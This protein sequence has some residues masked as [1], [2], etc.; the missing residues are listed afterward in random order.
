MTNIKI[1]A[2]KLRLAVADVLPV[3]KRTPEILPVSRAIVAIDDGLL[4]FTCS[5]RFILQ[6]T[7]VPQSDKGAE[8]G[9]R[10]EFAL[11]VNGVTALKPVAG[12]T[13]VE[14]SVGEASMTVKQYKNGHLLPTQECPIFGMADVPNYAPFV[15]IVS[16]INA[17]L[18]AN[19][20]SGAIAR[21]DVSRIKHIKNVTLLSAGAGEESGGK[22]PVKGFYVAGW[23]GFPMPNTEGVR[24]EGLIMPISIPG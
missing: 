13:D 4:T 16:D 24:T 2:A 22:S 23:H 17:Y 8:T 1:A 19:P 14:I 3:I 5:D 15:D 7:F 20:S 18:E 11:D 10:A 9:V 6:R 12:A 21:F